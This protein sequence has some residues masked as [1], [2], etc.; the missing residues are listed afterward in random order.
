MLTGYIIIQHSVKT[1]FP[2][3]SALTEMAPNV[4]TD[5]TDSIYRKAIQRK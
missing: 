5:N 1:F 4:D 3:I 2:D